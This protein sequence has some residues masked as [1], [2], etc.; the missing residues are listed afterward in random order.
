M[1]RPERF[2]TDRA[3]VKFIALVTAILLAV[4]LGIVTL[5]SVFGIIPAALMEVTQ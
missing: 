3:A 4:V 2:K 1:T 5:L